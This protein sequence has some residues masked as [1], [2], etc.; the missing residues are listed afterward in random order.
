MSSPERPRAIVFDL[1]NT[2]AFN[3]QDVNPFD[4]LLEGLGLDARRSA[5]RH[6][7]EGPFMETPF[8]TLDH[9]LDHLSSLLDRPVRDR[10]RIRTIWEEADRTARLFPDV[11][12]AL[13]ALRGRFRLALLS[14]TQPFGMGGILER[15]PL[16]ELDVVVLSYEHRMAKPDPRF[17]A[18]PA[19]ELGAEPASL[20]MVG[21]SMGNDVRPALQAG[22]GTAFLLDRTGWAPDRLRLR[23]GEATPPI[24]RDLRDLADLLDELEPGSDS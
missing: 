8:E 9:A 16:D 13:E 4:A 20:V 2:L 22:Y 10:E 19:E 3:D 23:D 24:L 6:A 14:N 17:F 5:D 7:V 11:I 1:W 15:S 18:A 12:E 21:D